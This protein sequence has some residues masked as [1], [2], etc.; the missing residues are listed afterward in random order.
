[1]LRTKRLSTR[2]TVK[3]AAFDIRYPEHPGSDHSLFEASLRTN[4]CRQWHSVVWWSHHPLDYVLGPI[5]LRGSA[6]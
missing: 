2:L 1:M 5:S 3:S 6:R 4:F